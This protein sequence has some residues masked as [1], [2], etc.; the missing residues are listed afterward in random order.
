MTTP[1]T[2]FDQLGLPAPIMAAIADLGYEPR[3]R[4]V[5]YELVD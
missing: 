1:T 2:S 5:F 3:Q 4:N